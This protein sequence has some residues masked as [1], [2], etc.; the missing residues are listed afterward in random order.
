MAWVHHLRLVLRTALLFGL[1]LVLSTGSA[2]AAFPAG[3]VAGFGN[4]LVAGRIPARFGCRLEN[5][6]IEES[7]AD[8]A[9]DLRVLVRKLLVAGDS[10]QQ[11][12]DYIVARYGIFVLLDLPFEPVTWLLW[13]GTPGAAAG[14][15]RRAGV[16]GAA[17]AP[18]SDGAGADPG[19]AR[20]GRGIA[21]R[22]RMVW[23]WVCA[24]LLTLA[25]LLALL[26]PLVRQPPLQRAAEPVPA[27]Y[28]RQLADLDAELAQGRL[29]AEQAA[30]T[31]SD[32]TRR[33]LAAA[34]CRDPRTAAATGRGAEHRGGSAPRSASPRCCRRRRRS[35][36]RGRHAWRRRSQRRDRRAAAAWYGRA[37]RGGA[38][39]QDAL[40][41]APG[42]LKGWVLLARTLAAL[43]RF[44]EARDAYAHAIA[45]AP[46]ETGLHAELGEVLVLAAQG[47]VTPAAEA[48]FAKAPGD[49]RSRYYR[50]DATLQAGD[51][52][53][54]RKQLR[55]CWPR[56]RPTRHGARP[57]PT[58]S[59]NW[60]RMKSPRRTP[61]G[62]PQQLRGRARR[63]SP[64][65]DRCRRNSA[66]R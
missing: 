53:G 13:V 25:A 39:H 43:G 57:S 5:Q 17:A 44:P 32:I 62:R 31:R 63:T 19:R 6:S 66:R 54:A 7:N 21:E 9:H 22:K 18:R 15:G 29:T 48:E 16:A 47:K 23:F 30:A 52:A 51:A 41:Q 58:G 46:G 65:P 42:D 4:I 1:L 14:S 20:A 27:L 11:V 40:Q 36:F 10:N 37:R 49:P 61:G 59:P 45:L 34:E 3:S 56:P 38:A 64:P 55:A 2:S 8:L 26:R 12:R 50:A 33:M 60:R 35:L 28:R 24:G